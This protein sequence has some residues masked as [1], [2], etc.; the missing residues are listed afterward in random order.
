MDRKK[1]A[2]I[3]MLGGALVLSLASMGAQAAAG[4][5]AGTV[6]TITGAA[7]NFVKSTF[8]PKCSASTYVNYTDGGSDFGVQGSSA[9]G[10]VYYGASTAGGTVTGCSTASSAITGAGTPSATNGCS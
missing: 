3:V 10:K 5:T 7:S 8:S 2:E 9:K 6:G 4:C 1:T